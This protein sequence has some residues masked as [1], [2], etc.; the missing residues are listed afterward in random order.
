ML[1][2]W[3]I[4]WGIILFGL[5][6]IPAIAEEIEYRQWLQEIEEENRRKK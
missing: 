4:F 3:I 2:F 6:A 1:I 5:A